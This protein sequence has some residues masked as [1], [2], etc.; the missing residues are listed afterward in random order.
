MTTQAI[1]R[2]GVAK[3][4]FGGLEPRHL[5]LIAC[6]VAVSALFALVTP[7]FLSV[8][9]AL[10]VGRAAA[11][12]LVV[13][14]GA[15]LV[16]TS[17]EV[18]LTPGSVVGLVAVAIPAMIDNRLPMQVFLLLALGLG[19]LIGAINATITL[20]L[21][22]PSFLATLGM[23]AILRGIAVNLSTQP[24][25]VRSTAFIDVFTGDFLGVPLLLI[26]AVVVVLVAVWFVARARAWLRVR[27]VGSNEVSARLVGV[28][29]RRTKT[30]VFVAAGMLS[31]LGGIFLL[32]RT[33]TGISAESGL[34]LELNA[35]AA[36]LLGGARLGGGRGSVLGTALGALLLTLVLYGIA[37][38]GLS[39]A[40]Q[41]LVQGGILV[42]VVLAMRK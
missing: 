12:L 32:G 5:V 7:S 36:A 25:Q 6:M 35:I 13:S 30:V 19:A 9:S 22:V 38:M 39:A 10:D 27:A 3:G 14:I 33:L 37:G 16:I 26:Y 21:Y 24:R 28:S 2:R 41:Y 23:M 4:L 34:G 8:Q 15:T 1:G 17:G 11:V 20:R 29:P 18:D 31:A 42:L 40:W